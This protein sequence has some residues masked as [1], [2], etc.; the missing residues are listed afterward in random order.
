M[1]LPGAATMLFPMLFHVGFGFIGGLR[2]SETATCTSLVRPSASSERGQRVME[3]G[4]SERER[5]RERERGERERK[6]K[7]ERE[8]EREQKR[9]EPSETR[10][11]GS[12]PRTERPDRCDREYGWPS[13]SQCVRRRRA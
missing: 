8:I 7:R 3:G 11:G 13:D 9:M 10:L 2:S 1:S 4:S 12:W 6:K 5:E